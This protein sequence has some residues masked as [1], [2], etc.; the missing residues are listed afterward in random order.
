MSASDGSATS[1]ANPQDTGVVTDKTARWMVAIAGDVQR[2]Y[3]TNRYVG[4]K[5]Q[6]A[7][8]RGQSLRLSAR[9]DNGRPIPAQEM[10]YATSLIALSRN[11][12]AGIGISVFTAFVARRTQFHQ[13]R[14]AAETG[15]EP[16]RFAALRS[17]I[18]HYLAEHGQGLTRARL[19]ALSGIYNRLLRQ[20][21]VMSYLDG[22]GVLALLL[23][24]AAPFVWIMRK[25]QFKKSSSAGE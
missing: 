6:P 10:G 19:K 24:L 3:G 21:S 5:R 13:T 14:L 4:R 20:A 8:H 9:H 1:F 23:L 18:A 22:F 25:P 16:H 11:L 15:D 17:A 7:L 12:G 2:D